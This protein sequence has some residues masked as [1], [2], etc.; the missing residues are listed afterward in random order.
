MNHKNAGLQGLENMRVHD[1]H[2][3]GLQYSVNEVNYST[4]EIIIVVTN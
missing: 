2:G 4:D 1:G 3:G